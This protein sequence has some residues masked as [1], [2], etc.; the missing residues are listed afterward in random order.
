MPSPI[1]PAEFGDLQFVFVTH[2]H[3]D[4]MDPVTLASFSSFTVLQI[5]RSCG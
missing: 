3:G 1:E 5:H 2:G 4:H